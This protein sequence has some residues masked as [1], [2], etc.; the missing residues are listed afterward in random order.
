M[1]Q[2]GEAKIEAAE[3]RDDDEEAEHRRGWEALSVPPSEPSLRFLPRAR[4][5]PPVRSRAR[6]AVPAAAS[7]TSSPTFQDKTDL[8]EAGRLLRSLQE[9]MNGR[10]K[11]RADRS[12]VN[13]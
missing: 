3:D 8:F 11:P 4:G 12:H 9:V 13:T 1:S 2:D 10:L 5:A 7:R 6:A